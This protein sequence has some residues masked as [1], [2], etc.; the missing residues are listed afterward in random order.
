MI[1]GI[2]FEVLLALAYAVFL[3][4]AAFLLEFLAR[5]SH[6]RSHDYARAGFVFFR[7]RDAW[8]CPAGKQ[9]TR[10]EAD[11]RRNIV[12]YRAPAHACNACSVKLNCTDSD[13][14]RLL[15]H[16]LDSWV[17][18]EL[19]HF[20]RGISL[21]LLVLA[22]VILLVESFRFPAPADR[23]PLLS[24]LIPASIAVL[25]SCATLRPRDERNQA[26]EKI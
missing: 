8:E 17:D 15:E 18:S 4:G 13:E 5:Q 16:R 24:F 10:V 23:L 21:V 26:A 11:D 14:G 3:G 20:H 1:S 7:D 19:R 6:Q 25:K 12:Y 2:H 9:L 22:T